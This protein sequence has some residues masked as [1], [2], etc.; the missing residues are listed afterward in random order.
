MVVVNTVALGS[1]KQAQHVDEDGGKR[2]RGEDETV[3][4]RRRN[5]DDDEG[6]NEE[7]QEQENE[8][9]EGFESRRSHTDLGQ[10]GQ[11]DFDLKEKI[12][13]DRRKSFLDLMSFVL[14]ICPLPPK[15]PH[16]ISKLLWK[17]VL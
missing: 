5:D 14:N 9:E 17:P 13:E 2:G 16:L 3:K 4:G 8:G 15:Y 11:N 12:E 1:R 10:F 6:R 7:N